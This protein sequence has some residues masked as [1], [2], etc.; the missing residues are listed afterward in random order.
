MTADGW[1]HAVRQQVGLGRFLP[2]GGPRDGAWITERAAEAALRHTAARG[3]PGVRLDGVRIALADPDRTDEPA[4]PPPP[5]ALPPGALRLT[6]EFAATAAQPLPATASRLRAALADAAAERL[7]L[8]VAEVDLRATELL[9]EEPAPAPPAA[10]PEPEP[11][12][13]E[14]GDSETGRVAAAVLA[15]PGVTRLTGA[16]G[17]PVQLTERP[18]GAALP[19]RHVRVDLAVRADHRA[20]DVARAVRAAV[21]EA[22]PD[23]PT[24]AVLVTAVD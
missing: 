5:G 3:V 21:S 7:G 15:V 18:G 6:A 19:R 1:A 10:P 17:R 12:A 20:L 14:P 16:T 11:R 24:V 9:D 8:S 22:L 4:V 2:L 23:R 13:A